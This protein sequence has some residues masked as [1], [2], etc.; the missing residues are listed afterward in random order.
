MLFAICGFS[1]P[2]MAFA[3]VTSKK[4][5]AVSRSIFNVLEFA[6]CSIL[7]FN[8]PSKSSAISSNVYK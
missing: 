2:E 7:P 5:C 1:Y 4:Y 6:K 8:F 3:P